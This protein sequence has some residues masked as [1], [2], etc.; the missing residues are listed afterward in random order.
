MVDF[1]PNYTPLTSC[2][3]VAGLAS[4]EWCKSEAESERV[5]PESD[6]MSDV[7]IL[8]LNDQI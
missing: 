4:R 5:R 3:S 6:A 2:G 8:I 1:L 7:I